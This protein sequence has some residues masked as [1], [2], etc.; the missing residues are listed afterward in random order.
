M[1][2]EREGGKRKRQKNQELGLLRGRLFLLCFLGGGWRMGPW[3]VGLESLVTGFDL[4]Q[5]EP[6][7]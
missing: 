3:G 6:Q 7:T 1:A 2:T 5:K 4:V